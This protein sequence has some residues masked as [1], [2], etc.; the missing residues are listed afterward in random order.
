MKGISDNK[1]GFKIHS[2]FNHI[3]LFQNKKKEIKGN[4]KEEVKKIK[5]IVIINFLWLISFN[6]TINKIKIKKIKSIFILSYYKL[7]S[8]YKQKY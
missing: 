2:K 3:F 6:L 4:K 7:F 1:L 5:K 8:Q